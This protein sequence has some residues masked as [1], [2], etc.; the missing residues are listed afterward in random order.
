M[1]IKTKSNLHFHFSNTGKFN[2]GIL[3]LK[4]NIKLSLARQKKN[5]TKH[6][7]DHYVRGKHCK[8]EY[9]FIRKIETAY[10]G[11]YAFD[12]NLN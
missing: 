1:K 8:T 3:V 2:S 11:C 4:I 10:F 9:S 7:Q 5:T 6:S 12:L